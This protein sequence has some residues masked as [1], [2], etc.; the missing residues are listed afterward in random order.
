MSLRGGRLDRRLC[1]EK[2]EEEEKKER[3]EEEGVSIFVPL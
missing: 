3:E 1:M 2:E